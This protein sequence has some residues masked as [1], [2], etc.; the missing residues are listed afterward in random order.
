[1]LLQIGPLLR[2]GPN[3]ITDG[4]FITLGSSYY[5][6]AFYTPPLNKIGLEGLHPARQSAHTLS[7]IL[8]EGTGQLYTGCI[9]VAPSFVNLV[10]EIV[11]E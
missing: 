6:C 1:M 3:G 7:P 4:T 8:S 9:C 5:T 11:P 10:L 2:L